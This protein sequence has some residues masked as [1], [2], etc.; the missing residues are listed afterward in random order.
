MNRSEAKI[1]SICVKD[2]N[3]VINCP[4]QEWKE[5]DIPVLDKE[6][7]E[8]VSRFIEEYYNRV[9]KGLLDYNTAKKERD[10][11]FE[12]LLELLK[13]CKDID[14]KTHIEEC[15]SSRDFYVSVNVLINDIFKLEDE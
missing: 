14:L 9:R 2:I 1:M 6:T 15:I 10:A 11:Y 8:Y 5:C 7:K 3:K 12:E 13:D 4:W